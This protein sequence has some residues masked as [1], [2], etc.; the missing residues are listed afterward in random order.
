MAR[1]TDLS[2]ELISKILDFSDW[3][4]YVQLA[5][6][7]R[8]LANCSQR[9]MARHSKCHA[10]YKA[11]SDISP[12]TLPALCRALLRDPV[13]V[14]HV[15]ALEFWGE[16]TVWRDWERYGVP[17]PS[18]L[19]GVEPQR[20]GH[21]VWDAGSVFEKYELDAFERLMQNKIQLSAEKSKSWRDKIEGGDDGALK[22]MLVALC[23]NLQAVRFVKYTEPER[24]EGVAGEN[25]EEE[26]PYQ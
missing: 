15:F 20:D 12:D 4:A 11:T 26:K 9:I 23:P 25:E 24:E 3:P 22:G 19:G 14:S 17:L 2:P 21:S 13:A 5:L 16:R 1:L 6:S 10:R 7:C 8:Y 18:V